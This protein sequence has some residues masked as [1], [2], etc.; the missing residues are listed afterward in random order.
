MVEAKI[1]LRF[2]LRY[3]CK[4]NTVIIYNSTVSLTE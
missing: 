3:I 4:L 2:N 1:H